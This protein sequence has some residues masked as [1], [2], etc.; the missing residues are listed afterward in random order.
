MIVSTK[1]LKELIDYSLTPE[2]LESGLTSLGLEC[3]YK[4]DVSSF[5]GIVVG[6]ILSATKDVS[7][8]SIAPKTARTSPALRIIGKY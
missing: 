4:A 8:E 6:K 3:T 2:E 1:W 5:S 7:R